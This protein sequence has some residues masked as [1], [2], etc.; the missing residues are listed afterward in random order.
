[1]KEIN[2]IEA[3]DNVLDLTWSE[4]LDD[5]ASASRSGLDIGG[6]KAS[7]AIIAWTPAGADG[8]FAKTAG[9][10]KVGPLIESGQPVWTLPYMMSAGAAYAYV[11]GLSGA[12]AVAQVFITINEIVVRDGIPVEAAHEAFLAIEEYA[13]RIA[14]RYPG[15]NR[16]L[17]VSMPYCPKAWRRLRRRDWQ[18]RQGY[19]DRD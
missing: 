19:V 16:S 2:E 9:T 13:S 4:L 14:S 1:M 11:R 12:E 3:P 6:I 18:L 7:E 15:F 5:E 17:R 8:S 10:V